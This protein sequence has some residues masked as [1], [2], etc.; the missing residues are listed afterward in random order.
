M[1][2][3]MQLIDAK[4]GRYLATC[5]TLDHAVAMAAKL[6]QADPMLVVQIR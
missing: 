1:E 2:N 6:V 4:T 3:T 5:A